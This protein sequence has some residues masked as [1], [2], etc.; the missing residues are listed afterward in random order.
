MDNTT[1]SGKTDWE[2][3]KGPVQRDFAE[4]IAQLALF[5]SGKE[6]LLQDSNAVEALQQV[7]A[8]GWTEESR[9]SA[10]SALLA[11]SDRQ[12]VDVEHDQATRDQGQQRHVML[13]YQWGSQVMARRIVNELQVRGYLTWF[14]AWNPLARS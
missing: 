10:E 5:P 11:L 6:A 13:S 8:E 1:A 4:A 2:G 3:A 7:A 12:P 14:G 9:L